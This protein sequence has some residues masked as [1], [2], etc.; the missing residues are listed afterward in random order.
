MNM[1]VHEEWKMAWEEAL[2]LPGDF[3]KLEDSAVKEL[4]EYLLIPQ[5]KIKDILP[6][7][8]NLLAEEWRNMNINEANEVS[9]KS[10]YNNTQLEIFELM[11]WHV[12]KLNTGPLNYVCA[13]EIAKEL[14]IKEYLDYGSG[15]GSGAILFA[16]NGFNVACADISE[17]LAKFIK[18][19]FDKRNLRVNFIDLRISALSKNTYDMITCFDVLEHVFNPGALLKQLRNALREN[20]ILI[21]NNLFYEKDKNKPMH[22]SEVNLDT[23]IRYLGFNNCKFSERFKKSCSNP[24]FVLKKVRRILFIN[25][26]FYIYDYLY[27]KFFIKLIRKLK[28]H[29]KYVY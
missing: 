7:A 4:S 2:M 17:P 25:Y 14:E 26:L 16:K 5:E 9:I 27:L 29:R 20:G 23:R 24:V 18:Y 10:F 13:M 21:V 11:N 12:N 6:K 1:L 3:K 19:R 8:E 15:I 28:R 22:I